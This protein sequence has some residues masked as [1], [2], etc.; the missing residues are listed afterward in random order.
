MVSLQCYKKRFGD[1]EI[2]PYFCFSKLKVMALFGFEQAN[3]SIPTAKRL[4]SRYYNKQ[5]KT[6]AIE[7]FRYILVNNRGVLVFSRRNKIMPNGEVIFG[8]WS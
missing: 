1:I 2:Y 5:S 8:K 7:S 6:K 4:A 3:V